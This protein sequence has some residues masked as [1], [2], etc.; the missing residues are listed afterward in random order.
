MINTYRQIPIGVKKNNNQQR[1]KKL[2]L[3]RSKY[4]GIIN[5]ISSPV[6]STNRFINLALD[7]VGDNSQGRQFLLESKQGIKKTAALLKRLNDYS[8]KIEK[9]IVE[10]AKINE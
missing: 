10:M 1:F 3:L 7:T 5:E 2:S 4:K 6:D 9:E 8:L